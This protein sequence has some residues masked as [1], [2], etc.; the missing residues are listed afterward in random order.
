MSHL[1]IQNLGETAVL[2]GTGQPKWQIESGV[3]NIQIRQDHSGVIVQLENRFG[4]IAHAFHNARR[5]RIDGGVFQNIATDTHSI[6]HGTA[7]ARTNTR[8]H[9]ATEHRVPGIQGV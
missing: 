1:R 5:Q 2:V 9:H 8:T 7:Q 3:F 6:R 4:L